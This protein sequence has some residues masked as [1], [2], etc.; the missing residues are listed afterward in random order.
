MSIRVG[1]LDGVDTVWAP[2]NHV[3]TDPI[4]PDG[5]A[6]ANSGAIQFF[7][8]GFAGLSREADVQLTWGARVRSRR[9]AMSLTMS[10]SSSGRMPEPVMAS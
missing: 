7:G 6:P 5:Q 3:D 1:H 8:Y 2:I 10:R 4:T 9:F